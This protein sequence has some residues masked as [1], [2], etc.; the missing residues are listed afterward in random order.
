MANLDV[1]VVEAVIN[2]NFKTLGEQVG[3]NTGNHQHRLQLIAESSTGQIIN[4][5]NSL[6][7]VE[8]MSVAT[9]ARGD[10]SKELAALTGAISGMQQMIKGAQTTP[11]VTA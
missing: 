1:G 9:V 5:L 11:P 3:S 7:P 10:L 4:R 2:S 6:D 8:A